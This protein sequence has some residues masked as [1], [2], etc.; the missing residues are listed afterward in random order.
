MDV[1]CVVK[2]DDQ[3]GGGPCWSPQNG[4]L[5]WLDILGR[6]LAWYEPESD[7]RGAF[8]LP[9]RASVVA[10]RAQG[11]LIMATEKGLAFCDPDKGTLEMVRAYALPERF[12]SGDGMIDPDGNFWW[13]I[14]DEQGG[15][16]TGAIYRTR[17]DLETE[18]VLTGI[19]VPAS[20]AMSPDRKTLYVADAKLQSIFA[21]L[22]TDLS[23]ATLFAH[24]AGAP[25]TPA[26][27]AVDARGFVW[28]AQPGGWRIARYAPNGGM[29]R[30]IPTPI[31]SPTHCAFGGKALTTL[32]V[33][34]AKDGL[35]L[36]ARPQQ[37]LAGGLFAIETGVRGLPLPMFAG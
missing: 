27:S 12:R 23:K 14:V 31:Q 16:R 6:R 7:E 11:G 32:F 20:L 9:L 25:A 34:S 26:G 2:A 24:T 19:H 1:R 4:R 36:G 22:M 30:A 37:P 3:L 13:S 28:N 21:H 35:P 5:Y 33:T 8:D 15:E 17:P 29:E 18:A 10:P